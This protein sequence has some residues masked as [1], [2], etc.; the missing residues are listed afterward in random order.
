MKE[1]GTQKRIYDMAAVIK[2][3]PMEVFM[4]VTGKVTKRM[5]V[6]DLFTP[7]VIYMMVTGEM[8]KLMDLGNTLIRTEPSMKDIGKMINNMERAKNNG[9]MVLN[10]KVNINMERKMVSVNSVG[11][12]NLAIVATSSIT[13]SMDKELIPGPTVEFLTV[14]GTTIK[15]MVQ[16][17]SLGLMVVDMKAS[18]SWIK[19]KVMEFSIGLMVVGTMDTGKMVNKRVW[20]FILMPRKK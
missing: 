18:I 11:L 13:I 8:I 1:N 3:G 17:L 2:Y 5:D 10:M 15:C 9:Q 14:T 4:M 12:I 16:V 20:E 6:D 19:K 7:M